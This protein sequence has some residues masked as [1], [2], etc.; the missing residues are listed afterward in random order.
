MS[1]LCC[2]KFGY[3]D[4]STEAELDKA[5]KLNGKKFLGLEMKL[6]KAKSKESIQVNKKGK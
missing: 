5:L 3:V 2:R 4:F 1:L 6:E